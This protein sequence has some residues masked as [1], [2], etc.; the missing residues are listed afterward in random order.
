MKKKKSILFVIDILKYG[1]AQRV[2][3]NHAKFLRRQ[4]IK[5]SVFSIKDD[6][7]F[8][9]PEGINVYKALSK[10][11]KITENIFYILEKLH[12]AVKRHDLI[13]GFMD[14][15]TNYITVLSSKIN[16]KP[17][18][19]SVRNTLSEEINKFDYKRINYD[20]TMLT[21]NMADKV[22]CPARYIQNDVVSNFKIH[23]RKTKVLN[24][25]VDI[26][27]INA[28][29][30]QKIEPEYKEAFNGKTILSI[31]RLERQKNYKTLI[32]A[33]RHLLKS[34]KEDV[35]LVI[36][37]EGS[38]REELEN[39]IERTGLEK[40]VFLIGKQHNI[41]KFLHHSDMFVLPS[42]YEGMP[43]VI[44]EA[45]AV[46][47]PV[48]ASN[49][50]PVREIIF[51]GK[52]GLLFETNN[53]KDMSEKIFSLLTDTKKAAEIKERA[54][55]DIESYGID[56]IGFQLMNVLGLRG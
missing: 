53:I 46:G 48:V 4:G 2:L 7:E 11:Q 39:V 23:R 16:K 24:N 19:I 15:I 49:L 20:L 43:N 35:K 9:I 34:Y 30:K 27:L 25:P 50:G 1:G 52:N 6:I 45:M 40:K 41:Y 37:G 5:V 33:F 26:K 51:D 56:K 47:V 28:L 32:Y 36:I 22:I 29:K 14:F 12:E 55:K 21:Y 18:F 38:L 10:D 17:V 42:I 3:L 44:L 31:G 13:I 54:S 8:N